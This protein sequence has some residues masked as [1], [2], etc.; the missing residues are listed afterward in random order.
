V[1]LGLVSLLTL[2]VGGTAHAQAR[3]AYF[4][5]YGTVC[6]APDVAAAAGGSGPVKSS[7]VSQASN[8]LIHAFIE[9]VAK[10]RSAER[11]LDREQLPDETLTSCSRAIAALSAA[12]CELIPLY[13][14]G[15]DEIRAEWLCNGRSSFMAFFT[16]KNGKISNI[17]AM[18]GTNAPVVV[19]RP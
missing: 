12:E 6:A 9:S 3:E 8:K 2:L 5:H 4:G 14:L 15:D 19:Y 1:A 11:F 10:G 18:D 17:W 16:V 7:P 13:M